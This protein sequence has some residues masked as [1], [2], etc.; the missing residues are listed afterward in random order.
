MI[1]GKIGTGE[2]RIGGNHPGDGWVE[3]AEPRPTPESVA[4][5]D[6]KWGEKV[7]TSKEV[8]G[9]RDE[10]LRACDWT[11]LSDTALTE[12]QATAWAAYRQALRDVPQQTG[13]PNSVTW[14]NKPE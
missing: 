12:E 2:Q 9:R 8:R 11:Q 13:F 6:G 3:M 7:P 4:Q 5:F 10:L 1:Y 14:P